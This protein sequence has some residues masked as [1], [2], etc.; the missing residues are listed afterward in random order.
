MKIP[1]WWRVTYYYDRIVE[2]VT[3]FYDRR[4]EDVIYFYDRRAEDII[5]LNSS[6]RDFKAFVVMSY[7][8]W[9]FKNKN[10]LDGV[11][12]IGFAKGDFG[13]AESMRLITNSIKT[14]NIDF[15]VNNSA[16]AENHPK[17]NEELNPYII[18]ETPYKVN[19]FTYNSDFTI[20]YCKGLFFDKGNSYPTKKQYNIAYGYWEL[21]EYP[22]EWQKQ[23]KYIQEIW[24]PTKFIKEVIDKY[25]KLPVIH[26]PLAVDFKLPVN[27]TRSQFNLPEDKILYLFTF[28]MSSFTSRKNPEAVIKAFCKAFPVEGNENVTLVIKV[29]RIPTVKE[30]TLRFELLCKEVAFDPR[31]QIIDKVLD[32]NSILGLINVCDCYVSMHRAEGF[33]LGM[34]EAM[35]MGKVVIGT[36]YSGNTDFMNEENAC[37]VNYTLIPVHKEEYVHVE[38]GAVWAEPDVDH[39]A[40][41]MKKVYEDK[42]FVKKK[43]EAAKLYI[44]TYH[45]FKT[46]GER[47]EKRLREIF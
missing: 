32:R 31:I 22:K 13:L 38:D 28:D 11:N 6:A 47:Y 12:I 44:D 1:G 46:I 37:L 24:A 20:S 16:D 30:Q 40:F 41:Y 10:L 3:Y 23:D 7:M 45:N 14:T 17:T 34:A 43:S 39:A 36:N 8:K 35:K 4:V 33:G 25:S 21:S 19:L 2:G 15:G 42:E 27:Y 5:E 26:M 18:K 29:N 9:R